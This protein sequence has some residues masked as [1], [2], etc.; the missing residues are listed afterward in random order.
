MGSE[1]DAEPLH[2]RDEL[3]RSEVL[4]AVEDHVLQKV[5]QSPLVIGF[6]QGASSD[7]KAD[8]ELARRLGIGIDDVF[9]AIIHRA[10]DGIG[11]GLEI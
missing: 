4:G 3:G 11:I 2:L 10:E 8:R 6:H 1:L 5:R 7:V 9:E